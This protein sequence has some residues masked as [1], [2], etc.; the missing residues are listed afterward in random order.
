MPFLEWRSNESKPLQPPIELRSI[1]SETTESV[2][3]RM[4]RQTRKRITA[5]SSRKSRDRLVDQWLYALSIKCVY[6]QDFTYFIHRDH[7]GHSNLKHFMLVWLIDGKRQVNYIMSTDPQL[8]SRTFCT[9]SFL[10]V[11]LALISVSHQ[12]N[13]YPLRA[14]Y[15]GSCTFPI[16]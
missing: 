7:S 14:P 1:V 2:S 16:S 11:L 4:A 13:Y 8:G 12:A 10:L 3:G 9:F 15:W 6:L 5:L